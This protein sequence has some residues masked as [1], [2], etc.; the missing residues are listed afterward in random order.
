MQDSFPFLAKEVSQGGKEHLGLPASWAGVEALGAL[1]PV[2][3]G[4][5]E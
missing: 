5:A 1:S 2:C 4:A 3:V